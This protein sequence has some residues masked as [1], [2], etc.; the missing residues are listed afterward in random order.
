MAKSAGASYVLVG[1]SERRHNFGETNEIISKKIKAVSDAGLIAI[2]CIGESLEEKSKYRS[3]LKAQI[4]EGLSKMT[5]LSNVV[6]AYE[7]IWAIGTGKVATTVDIA[8]VHKFIKETV[9]EHFGVEAKVIYG[10]SI[11]PTNSAEILALDEVDGVLVGGA[12]LNA[13]DF[14][15]IAKSR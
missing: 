14:V 1:H 8:K 10:G 6:I 11:K 15:K 9:K 4:L 13:D 5:T 7:P 2:F 3:V 12:S